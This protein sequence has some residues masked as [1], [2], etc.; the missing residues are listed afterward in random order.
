MINCSHKEQANW[1]ETDQSGSEL[2][3]VEIIGVGNSPTH[4]VTALHSRAAPDPLGQAED[5]ES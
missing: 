1:L 5:V 4:T 3:K 2:S